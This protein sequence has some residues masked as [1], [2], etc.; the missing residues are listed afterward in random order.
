MA[1]PGLAPSATAPTAAAT[2]PTKVVETQAAMRDLCLGQIFWVRNVVEARLEDNARAAK[3]AEEQVVG[4]A[5]AIA[6]AIEPYYGGAAS[7]KLFG[8]LAGH[9]ESSAPISTLPTPAR[10]RIRTLRSRSSST[11]RVKSPCFS[12]VRTLTCP[13]KPCA[14]C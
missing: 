5:K 10:R 4:N 6:G 8:L 14:A 7:E 12:P 13:S 2:V 1:W 11:M 3:A 9:W